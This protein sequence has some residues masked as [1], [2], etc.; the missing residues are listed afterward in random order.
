MAAASKVFR[1]KAS[2]EIL[3]VVKTSHGSTKAAPLVAAYA[4]MKYSPVAV[5]TTNTAVVRY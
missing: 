3:T 2:I 1:S 5:K 4:E